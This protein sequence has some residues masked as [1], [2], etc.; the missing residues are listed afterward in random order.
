MAGQSLMD[1]SVRSHYIHWE[2]QDAEALCQSVSAVPLSRT[3]DIAG[4]E[5]V[6]FFDRTAPG[7]AMVAGDDSLAGEKADR[8]GFALSSRKNTPQCP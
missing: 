2:I 5:N 3:P 6:R 8:F 1:S 7:S 4:I